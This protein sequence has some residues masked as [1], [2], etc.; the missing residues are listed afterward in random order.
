[1]I[2]INAIKQGSVIQGMD[3]ENKVNKMFI[4]KAF[5]MGELETSAGQV[6]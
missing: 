6:I 2:Q 5:C 4:I 3:R 1:L